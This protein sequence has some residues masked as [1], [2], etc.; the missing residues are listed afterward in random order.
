[1]MK[2]QSY[3]EANTPVRGETRDRSG[4]AQRYTQMEQRSYR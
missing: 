2:M 3:G 4:Q 1:M